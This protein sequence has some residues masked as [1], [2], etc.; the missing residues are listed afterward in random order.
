[1]NSIL[2]ILIGVAILLLGTLFS[3]FVLKLPITIC[4]I[5]GAILG[6]LAICI[7]RVITNR[8]E[9]VREARL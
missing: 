4:F 1:M 9:G 5:I 3:F 6:G 8:E 2:R 7:V